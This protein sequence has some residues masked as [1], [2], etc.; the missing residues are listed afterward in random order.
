MLDRAHYRYL[1]AIRTLAMIRKLSLPV[2]QVNIADNVELM[3]VDYVQIALVLTN[4]LSNAAKY[5]PK[6]TPIIVNAS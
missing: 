5:A 2:V 1:S 3:N 6:E 4:L